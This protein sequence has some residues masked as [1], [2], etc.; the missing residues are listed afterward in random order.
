MCLPRSPLVIRPTPNLASSRSQRKEASPLEAEVL[1]TTPSTS[2][3]CPSLAGSHGLLGPALIHALL[4][5]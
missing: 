5:L 3:V 4:P 1:G 2:A